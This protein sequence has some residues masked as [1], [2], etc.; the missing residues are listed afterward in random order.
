MVVL[1]NKPG[2]LMEA[3]KAGIYL[4]LAGAGWVGGVGGGQERL[5]GGA[6]T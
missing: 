3:N 4:S 2:A 6:D 1:L 5:P